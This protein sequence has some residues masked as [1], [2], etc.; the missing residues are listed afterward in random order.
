MAKWKEQYDVGKETYSDGDVEDFIYQCVENKIEI[1]QLPIQ[2]ISYPIIYHLSEVREN[3]LNWYPFRAEARVLEVGAGCGAIT[4]MLCERVKEVVAVDI[5][6]RRAKINYLRHQ[7]YDNLELIVGNI[8]RM[9]FEKPFD[10]IILNGVLEYAGMF[11]ESETPYHTFLKHLKGYLKENGKFLIAIENK[12][13]IK[14]FAGSP[15]DHTN[16]Y[17]SGLNGYKN[18]LVKTFS[19]KELEEVLLECGMQKMKFYYPYPDYKFPQEIFTK[20][21]IARYGKRTFT[22][23]QDNHFQFFDMKEVCESLVKENVMERFANSFLIEASSTQAYVEDEIL[24][25]KVN[26]DRSKEHRI[27]TSIVKSTQGV[28]YVIKKAIHSEAAKHLQKMSIVAEQTETSYVQNLTGIYDEKQQ[29]LRYPYIDTVSL[30]EEINEILQCTSFTKE[31]KKVRI[32]LILDDFVDTCRKMAT[33]RENFRTEEFQCVF[34]TEQYQES[35]ECICPANID[36]ILSNVYWMEEN[37]VVIDPEWVFDFPI[38]VE[39]I[40]WRALHELSEGNIKLKEVINKSLLME[41]YDMIDQGKIEVFIKWANHFVENYLQADKMKR[42]YKPVL[43]YDLYGAADKILGQR[44]VV[45]LYYSLGDGFKEEQ[46]LFYEIRVVNKRFDVEF[47]L[48][49]I[50]A[51]ELRLDPAIRA[52]RCRLEKVEPNIGEASVK[53][54]DITKFI[55]DSN[56]RKE[57]WYEFS[58]NNPQYLI[59]LSEIDA[60]KIH[61]VGE[62][63]LL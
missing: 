27:C 21:S 12:L 1:D 46:K 25:V 9:E 13:G 17:F 49:E 43:P 10:Y 56:A 22:Y 15:E 33:F 58:S 5:S 6:P 51:V 2:D 14:Y 28:K 3:I 36:M 29:E 57:E 60:E 32:L 41:R 16:E 4:G 34:G 30:D 19:H 53:I 42:W 52:C 39:F 20:E 59:Q 61:I 31:E 63:E 24:Y 23:L 45:A 11:T 44:T 8:N 54:N 38:P 18:S 26:Q 47:S 40:I 62:L 48:K 35:C 50:Q 7:Q 37:Y 55:Q